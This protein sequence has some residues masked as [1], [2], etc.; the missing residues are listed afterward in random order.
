MGPLAQLISVDASDKARDLHETW[1]N[2]ILVLIALHLIAILYYRAR[3]RKLT[4]P[5]ITGRAEVEP[6]TEPMRPGKWWAAL[7]C[8]AIGIGITRWIIAGAPPFGP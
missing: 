2:V 5:M 3:G 8:L 1:F 4:L 7:I 6:G